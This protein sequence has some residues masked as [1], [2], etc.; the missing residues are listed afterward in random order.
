MAGLILDLVTGSPWG[1]SSLVFLLVV[2]LLKTSRQKWYSIIF[3]VA[4]VFLGGLIP[5]FILNRSLDFRQAV[6]MTALAV[7]LW[8][9][10]KPWK[11]VSENQ[12]GLEI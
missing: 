10:S 1:V 6:V 11:G 5:G 2:F 9:L 8:F 12:A 7:G 3:L 4:S